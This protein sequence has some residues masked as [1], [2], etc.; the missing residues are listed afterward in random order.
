MLHGP[1]TGGADLD[2]GFLGILQILGAIGV[3]QNEM[4]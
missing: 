2:C 3:G 4:E 1:E